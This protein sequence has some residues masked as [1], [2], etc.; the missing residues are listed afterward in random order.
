[1]VERFMQIYDFI[2]L[3]SCIFAGLID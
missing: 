2:P 3:K 1:L